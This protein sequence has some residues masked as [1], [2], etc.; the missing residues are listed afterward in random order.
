MIRELVHIKEIIVIYIIDNS[1]LP[2]ELVNN[3]KTIIT[4][5]D[6]LGDSESLVA[7]TDVKEITNVQL[8]KNLKNIQINVYIKAIYLDNI[9]GNYTSTIMQD[10]WDPS[11]PVTFYLPLS[12]HPKVSGYYLPSTFTVTPKNGITILKFNDEFLL[13][14]LRSL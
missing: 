4:G 2:T 5:I 8:L 10:M 14:D 6:R 1:K 9:E 12:P 13:A 7:V 11:K 3:L